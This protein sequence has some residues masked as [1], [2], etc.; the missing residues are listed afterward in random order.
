M[1]NKHRKVWKVVSRKVNSGKQTWPKRVS[2]P[3]SFDCWKEFCGQRILWT[4][5]WSHKFHIL[6]IV[7][8]WQVNRSSNFIVLATFVV[9]IQIYFPL[10]LS[11][12]IL[13]RM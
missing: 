12:Q 13:P 3:T 4:N 2:F 5:Y 6:I 7:Q 9:E 10:K 1:A 8:M 11:L